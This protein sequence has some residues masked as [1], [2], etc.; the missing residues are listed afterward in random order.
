MT[1]D[2]KKKHR[3]LRI[4]LVDDTTKLVIIDD[5]ASVREISDLIGEKIGLK[6]SEEFSLRKPGG[7]AKAR[8]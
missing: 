7:L 1:L 4:R 8:T 6:S 3:P 5:S 2:Y